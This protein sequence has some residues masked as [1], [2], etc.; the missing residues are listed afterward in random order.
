MANNELDYAQHLDIEKLIDYA[1]LETALKNA[2][3]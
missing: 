3:S 2:S 1:A